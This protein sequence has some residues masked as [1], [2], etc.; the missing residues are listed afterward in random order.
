MATTTPEFIDVFLV[1][2]VIIYMI[3]DD[4]YNF[5]RQLSTYELLVSG[6]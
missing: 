2:Q 1:M 3:K 4:E 5:E 6:C